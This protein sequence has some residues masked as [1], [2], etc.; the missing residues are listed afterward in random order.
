[1]TSLLQLWV[2]IGQSPGRDLDCGLPVG[3]LWYGYAQC[4]VHYNLP[5]IR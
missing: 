3:D 4:F 1:M 2:Q 5:M